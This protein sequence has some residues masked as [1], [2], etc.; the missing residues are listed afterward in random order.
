MQCYLSTGFYKKASAASG[1]PWQTI[2]FWKNSAPWWDEMCAKLTME[3]E[4]QYRAGWRK[5]LGGSLEAIEDRLLNG[6]HVMTKEGI[7]R[8]PVQA[9]DAV[10]IAGIAC[11]KLRVSL[12][13]PTRITK[14]A[15]DIDRMAAL[16]E[17]AMAD[18]AAR[19][20]LPESL[21][22]ETIQ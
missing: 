13:L 9:K 6:N 7:V 10:V 11:D 22:S 3:M 17:A 14:S 8:I 4:E 21:Q 20:K 16:R 5:V 2:A 1:V 18:Q 19:K 15:S 12:G